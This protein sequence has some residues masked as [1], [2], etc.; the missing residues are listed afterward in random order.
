MAD[1]M[2][3][4]NSLRAL[5]AVARNQSY[6]RAAE[7][8]R[9]TPAAVKQLVAKL[10][11]AM[12]GK[13][14][15]RRGRGIV[16]TDAAN[17]AKGD[18]GLAMLHMAEA[19]QKLRTPRATERL[20]ISVEASLATTWLVPR[21]E[22]FRRQHPNIGVLIDS[23]QRIVDLKRTDVDVAIRYAVALDPDLIT[24]RL[25]EDV[26]FPACSPA[27][28]KGPPAMLAQEQLAD[29]PLIHWDMSQLPWAKATRRWFDW[30][31]WAEKAGLG[32][33]DTTRGLRFS[34]Y[35]LAVQAAVSGRG[36]ILASGPILQDPIEAGLL[37]QPFTKSAMRTGI[38]YDLV[39]TD[40]ARQRPEVTAFADWLK[41][42]ARTATT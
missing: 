35:G 41:E 34:D 20:I 37:V 40:D 16:L 23:T 30:H 13:L 19:V 31:E 7:E 10:E 24:H 26:V 27:L 4:L 14:V 22:T 38:G 28:A 17:A 29:A 12:G 33:M 11:D 25:F 2:P 3:S 42:T 21:L 6:Q 15:E 18:L 5:E 9:V 32:N 36:F 8:L 39:M 1:W